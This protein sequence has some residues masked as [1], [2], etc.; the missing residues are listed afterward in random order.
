[1][2]DVVDIKS[3]IRAQVEE[4]KRLEAEQ[5]PDDPEQKTG[6]PDDPRFVHDCIRN[7]ER[8][9]GLMYC[10]LHK[11]QYLYNKIQARWYNWRGHYWQPD[12][13]TTAVDGVEAVALRYQQ[14]ALPISDEIAERNAAK[15]DAE[16]ELQRHRA[17]GNEAGI[18]AAE[19]TIDRLKVEIGKLN[20]DR[21]KL[22]KRADQLR[23]KT[24][25]EKCLWWAHCVPGRLAVRG[26]E[27]DKRPMLLPCANGVIDL[28]TGKLH[29]GNPDDLLIRAIPIEYDPDAKAP[30]W[31]PFLNEIHQ[32][33]A[34]KVACVRRL[35]GY[36]LTGLTTEQYIACFIGEGGNGKG[37]LFELMHYL[38]GPLAWSINPELILEQKNPRP[39]AGP[40]ADIVSLY[41]RRLVIASETDKNRR[42]GA[43][44][45]KRF[46]GGDTL[47]GRSPHDKDE[48]N[49]DPTHKLVLYT[50][51]A[52]LGMMEDFALRRRMLLFE[53]QLRYVQDVESNQ[54]SDPQNAH[55]YR[56]K[57][58]SLPV[59]LK[60]QAQGILAD[61]V[62]ACIEWQKHGISPPDSI[63]AAAE[64]HR[65]SE[66]HLARFVN[67]ACT[68]IEGD[69]DYRIRIGE[70]H[71]A[72]L[73]WYG[74]EVNNKDRYSPSKIA[75]GKELMRLG[76]RKESQG[77]QTWIY[78][79]KPPEFTME[80]Y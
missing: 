30:D 29:P 32:D 78:G 7:N 63:I 70:F 38:L 62:R 71:K 4:R 18:V 14:A 72:Y 26:D 13:M 22:Y 74:E 47:I 6:G 49:F 28:T 19:K 61:L 39:T 8:G 66:D 15:A 52:P 57:D 1:M 45:V 51:H 56:Q 50:N 41:G 46:T 43:A 58:A 55:L 21:A 60:Q 40:S 80:D 59:K 12:I 48:T 65:R 44:Q 34:E 64:A 54:R 5:S 69:D 67:E 77:G 73:R 20:S 42:I 33:D 31:M 3:Q 9:D 68:R 79:I 36:C 10:A 37:T 23:A 27:F 2:A 24:R 11:G 35:L 25:A 76:Y 53:Y 16:D 75:V 17:D